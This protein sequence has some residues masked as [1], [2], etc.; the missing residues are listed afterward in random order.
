MSSLY[1]WPS[2]PGLSLL[3]LFLASQVFLY[4]GRAP[5]HKAFDALG[6]GLGGSLRYASRSLREAG[7][8]MREKNREIAAASGRSSVQKRMHQEIQRVDAMIAKDL[9]RY[10]ELHQKL[11]E[12]VTTLESDYA[13]CGST[14][15]VAPGWGAAVEA[16]G[17]MPPQAD[18]LVA[19]MLGEIGKTAERSD[20]DALKEYRDAT[21]KRHKVLASMAPAW[22]EAK[23]TLASVG[24]AITRTLE[25]VARVDAHAEKLDALT[26][27]DGPG[28]R[29]SL[30]HNLNLFVVSAIVVGIA[31]AGA[32]VNFQLIALPMSE[33]VPSGSRVAGFSVPSIAALVLVLMEITA[34]VF[35][36]ESLGITSL[37]PN[38]DALPA[39]RRRIVTVVSLGALFFLA[40]VESSLAILRER[41]VEADAALSFSLAGSAPGA[42]SQSSI[43]MIGQALL[44]FVLP[45]VLALVAIPLET[46]ISTGGHVVLGATSGALSFAGGLFGFGSLCMKR[47]AFA[48]KSLVDVWVCVPLHA[49]RVF[50]ASR[51]PRE[52]VAPA[53]RIVA[54]ESRS[55]SPRPTG[56]LDELDLSS[57]NF[58]TRSGG[59]R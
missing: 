15:P 29:I 50:L 41:I 32:F 18:K 43:P 30:W 2:H 27:A 55:P 57:P 4:A 13:E 26:K 51:Q 58:V 33:L 56:S 17:K 47:G 39:N 37:F 24:G 40:T 20:K 54:K 19:K 35:V 28:A 52:S 6:R 59:S 53:P 1:L 38:L 9:G 42:A 23:A 8:L 25:G 31:A 12:L 21:A 10:P 3:V 45:F 34:G 44:G 11:D 36:T 16:V 7:R 5:L 14:P 48:A 46:L 49:E 22:K